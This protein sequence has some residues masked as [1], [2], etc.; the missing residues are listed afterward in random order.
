MFPI[1]EFF[2][3]E[4]SKKNG[5]WANRAIQFIRLNW[6]PLISQEEARR[7][8]A[9]L[10]SEQD[11]TFI[12]NLFQNTARINLTNENNRGPV[13]LNGLGQP[14]RAHN[15]E[16]VA[17][18]REMESLNFKPLPIWEKLRNVLVSEM[19]KMG[20]VV[21]VRSEDPTSVS[22]RVQDKA[23]IEHKN[24]LE[25]LFSYVYTTIG[26][27]PYKMKNHKARF[28][29]KHDNGNTQE[30]EEM[31]LDNQDPTDVSFFMDYFHKLDEE[32]A[33]QSIIDYTSSYNQWQLNIEKWVNDL[34]SKK[35]CAATSYVSDVTG[36]LETPYLAPETVFIY[37]GGRRQDFN[38][39]NAKGYERK[40]TIKE[41][42]DILGNKF[43]MEAN[44]NR[45]L[46][47]ITYTSQLEFTGVAPS[48]R[49]FVSGSEALGS[50]GGR[51]YSYNDFMTFKVALGRIEFTS[52]NQETFGEIKADKGFYENYQP[53]GGQKYANK[54]RW[55]TP[56]YKAFYLVI[57]QVDQILFDF[58]PLEY[59]DILGTTDFNM[60]FTI[61][62]YKDVGDSLAIQSAQIIDRVNEAWYKFVYE[63]RRAKPRGR[64]WNYDS[65][66]SSMMDLVGD[67]NISQFNK[68]QKVI[69]LL[70]SSPNEFYTFPVV[71]GKTYPM[72]GGQLNYD[73]PNGVS[74]ESMVWWEIMNNGIMMLKDMIGIAPLREG[75]PGNARDSMNNQFKA[76]EYSE[77]STYYI[78]DMLT[79]MFQQMSVKVNFF[80]QDII[81]YKEHNTLAYRF[82]QDAVGDE[83]LGKLEA[84]G[85]TAMHRFGI[86]VESL[87]QA[88]LRQKLDAILFEAIKNKT[89]T[90]AEYLLINDMKSVK[91]A[92][93]TFTLFE[94]RNRKLI[95]KAQQAQAQQ[96]Q[97]AQ[98]QLKQ[99]ELQIE[100]M[101]IDGM[102]QGKK[103]EADAAIQTHLINQKGGLAKTILK[104]NNDTEAI[105]HQ[106]NAD[107]QKEQ[108]LLNN[109]GQTT[110]PIPQQP[111]PPAAGPQQALPGQQQQQQQQP[112][113]AE[114]LRQD[115]V[116]Q[117]TAM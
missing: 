66:I 50:R 81:T 8:M 42:L 80:V 9:Y 62:T 84:L 30:F 3:T 54:A 13:I 17:L 58:G 20:P 27:A 64:G 83:T 113:G 77:A 93:L 95:E 55:E 72:A 36:A 68:L 85:K 19:K 73:V 61:I 74:K 48:Y 76:L 79:Y 15:S 104:Q 71:D 97:Q 67:T 89:I 56:T 94:Q 40:I 107:L 90:T 25:G 11:M 99:M 7:G 24:A 10:L 38:D 82:L 34:I 4:K 96:Q 23:L 53:E 87:N 51:N 35:A 59:G 115:V 98:M 117:P 29:E 75:D 43:D 6:Q 106:V 28:G 14:I 69:E 44:F 2:E 78:P 21:N 112:S 102:L 88:P 46:M 41:L 1:R 32:I 52:Q 105:Y 49:G 86:F 37:G 31:G 16:E 12:K 100:K 110:I 26:Q 18:L 39:A 91:K 63:M 111:M 116:P 92:F 101:K 108:V 45:L 103:I 114:Q 5:E 57:S 22:K 65:V 109:T 47:A 60:N 33:V 70:D